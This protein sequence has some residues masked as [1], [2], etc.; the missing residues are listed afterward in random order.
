MASQF[1]ERRI[2]KVRQRMRRLKDLGIAIG[3][4]KEANRN[5]PEN[6]EKMEDKTDSE[7]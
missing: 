1:A 3:Q 7:T 6:G 4:D 5:I 2:R